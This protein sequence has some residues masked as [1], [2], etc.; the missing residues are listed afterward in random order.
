[1]ENSKWVGWACVAGGML[2]SLGVLLVQ[3]LTLASVPPPGAGAL[4]VAD[5]DAGSL[6]EVDEELFLVRRVPC[7]WPLDL[8]RAADGGLFVL[9]SGNAGPHFG[10][11]LSVFNAEGVLQ[12]ETWLENCLDL[13]TREG[14][15]A[16]LVQP[17]ESG[18]RARVLAV[19]RDGRLDV[20]GEGDGWRAV[21]GWRGGVLVGSAAGRVEWLGG[22]GVTLPGSI[23]D[24]ASGAGALYALECGTRACVTRLDANLQPQW[25]HELD[26]AAAHLAVGGQGEVWVAASGSPRARCID[27]AGNTRWERTDLPLLGLDRALGGADGS[28]LLTAPGAVLRLDSTGKTLPGQG[29]FQFVSDLCR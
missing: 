18:N 12:S 20:L 7:P 10:Q 19:D 29:G 4:W 5:R 21:H 3:D 11:R 17:L 24:I 8:E 1:M 2:L 16:L 27:S 13:D 9:R 23:V 28:V 26:F 22:D 6:Y 15:C 25:R 14:R